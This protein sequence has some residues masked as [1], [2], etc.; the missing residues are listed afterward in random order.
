MEISVERGIQA[1]AQNKNSVFIPTDPGQ[2][3]VFQ[4]FPK[5]IMLKKKITE[6]EKKFKIFF[7]IF[8]A[9]I[10]IILTLTVLQTPFSTDGLKVDTI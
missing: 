3:E 5:E 7:F 10:L 4:E 8:G 1:Q 2:E 6:V 9:T